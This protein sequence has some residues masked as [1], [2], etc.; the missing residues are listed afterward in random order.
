MI[1]DKRFFYQGD[2]QRENTKRHE[3][4]YFLCASSCKNFVFLCGKPLAGDLIYPICMPTSLKR[5][6][7]KNIQHLF[8]ITISYKTCR[9]ANDVSV[10]VFACEFG[11]FF[12]P[13]YCGANALVLVGR[14]RNTIG[15]ATQ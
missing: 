12:A 14:D 9:Y 10:I 4:L 5:C 13:A 8:G 11:Q 3:E 2:A 7:H 6:I 1:F 15:A